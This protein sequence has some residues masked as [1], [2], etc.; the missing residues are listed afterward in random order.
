[1][2]LLVNWICLGI[3]SGIIAQN[4]GRSFFGYF[5]LGTLIP[6]VGLVIAL[7]VGRNTETADRR[8]VASGRG[9]KCPY[10]AD[11]IPT[12]SGRVPLFRA[13]PRPRG[14]IGR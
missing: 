8:Q 14:I 4:K 9:K 13:G 1:V 3:A 6:M 2:E 5:V 12:R 11:L 7:A 10:C